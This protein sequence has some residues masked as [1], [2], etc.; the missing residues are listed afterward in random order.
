MLSSEEIRNAMDIGRRQA[1]EVIAF[2]NRE[3]RVREVAIEKVAPL[4]LRPLAMEVPMAVRS[5]LGPQAQIVLVAEGDSWFDYPLNDVLRI[6]EDHYGYDV[7]SV[8]HKGDRVEEMAYADGQLE[9]F[10]RRIEKLLRRGTIPRAILLSGGG[11]DVAGNEFGFLVNHAASSIAGLN[12]SVLEGI[13]DERVKTAY[14]TIISR[15]TRVCEERVGQPLPIIVHGYDYPVPDGRGFLGGW[16]FLP[17]P[18]L[19]PGFREKGF[20]QLNDRIRLAKELMDRFNTMLG[21]VSA[22]PG[23]EHVHYIDLRGTLS[24]DQN[25][26]NDWANELHP[27]AEG[28]EKVTRKFAER[29][30]QLS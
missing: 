7:E 15:V 25:Y 1:V 4:R 12:A 26:Q 9:A 2:R 17:G 19:E 30:A 21:E 18:W 13:V 14:V 23:F 6:L 5:N 10:T 22:L 3:L 16:W 29:I 28:F 11:N 20:A 27:T 8:S 24:V